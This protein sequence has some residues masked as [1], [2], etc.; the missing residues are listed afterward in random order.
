M[1]VTRSLL[2]LL[3]SAL[4]LAADPVG[5]VR[6]A[7]ERLNGR[8]P[9]RVTYELQ[10]SVNNEGKLDN[11]KS[12]GKAAVEVEGNPSGYQIVVPRPVLDQVER[13][14]LA[15]DRN[16]K[17][18][19]PTANAL[20]QIDAVET[21]DV[22]DCAPRLLRLIDGAKVVSDAAGTWQGKPVRVLVLRGADRLDAEEAGRVKV[23]E[24]K[25]TLWLDAE[26]VPLAAEHMFSAKFSFL[27]FKGEMKQ[28]KSW[29][30]SRAGNRLIRARFESTQTTS[31]MGQKGLE[32]VVATARVH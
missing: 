21:A 23:A 25:I 20:R 11:D 10:R 30:L 2:V 26:Q 31:G 12:N 16:P 1:N 24:N 15:R 7:L 29:H 3:V 27:V 8:D 18:P 14:Q 5:D 19:T 6:A 32:T 17:L 4:P 22:L 13:E 9:I 28:K